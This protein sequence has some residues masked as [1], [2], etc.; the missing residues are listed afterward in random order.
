MIADTSFLFALYSGPDAHHAQ[1]LGKFGELMQSGE[2]ILIP[3]EVAIELCSLMTYRMSLGEALET[4]DMLFLDPM[5]VLE[6]FR[7]IY[8]ISAFLKELGASISYTDAVVLLHS[9]IA[10]QG[11]LTFDRQ[12]RSLSRKLT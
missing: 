4:I 12:M 5:F 1:A 11:I 10:R 6:D 8:E 9:R 3:S 7:S 2:C